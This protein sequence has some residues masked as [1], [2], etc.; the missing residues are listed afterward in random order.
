MAEDE[1][2]TLG[3][4]QIKNKVNRLNNVLIN[5]RNKACTSSKTE[6]E[7]WLCNSVT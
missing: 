7:H 5:I 6:T 3:R 1:I 4:Q 2:E